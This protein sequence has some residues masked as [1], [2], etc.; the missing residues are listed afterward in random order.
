MVHTA[1]GAPLRVPFSRK[2]NLSRLGVA[3]LLAT[4]FLVAAAPVAQARITHIQILTRGTAFGGH[5]FAGVGQYEFITGIATGEVDPNNPQNSLITDLALA[6]KNAAGHVVY[7]HN[8]YILQPLDGS[9]GN[10][11][12][13]YEP[14][15]RGG[16]TYQ[17]LNN[18]PTGTDDPAALTD[19]AVLDDS[20]L[21]TRGYTTVWSGW[22]NNLGPL[23]GLTATASFPI[24]GTPANPITGPG[25]EYI[26]SPPATFQLN[27]P[28]ASADQSK[29]TLTHRI[30]LDDTPVPVPA[31]GWTYV[32][33]T[34][35]ADGSAIP[36]G[37]IKLTTGPFVANDIYEFSYTAMN[38]TVNGL[39]LA[40][41][42]DFNSFL[43]Y[44]SH[45]D[46]GVQNPIKFHIDRIY[47]ETSSQPGRTLND[48]VHLGF[49]EDENHKQVFD[50][51]MQW[52]AAGDGLNMNYR[53]SQTKRTNRNRQELL[54]LE[55][56]YP[57]ANVPTF[58]PISGTSDWRYKRC[59]ET[60]TCPLATEFYSANEFWVKAGSLMST[61][62]TGK[63]DL[64]DHP[65]AR[66]YLLSSKQHG[67]AGNPASRGLC[68]Q[69]LNP[70]DSAPVQRALWTALDEWSM[71]GIQPPPSQV[72]TFRDGTLVPP[73]Q[74][75]VGFP[76]IP[77]VTY[78]GLKT[79]R[80]R[81]NYGKD[82]YQTFVPTINPPLISPP[83]YE[84]NP[85]NGPIYPSFVPKTD[86]D[87]NDIAGIRL[88]ELVVPLATYTGWGLRSG[89]W[90]NDGC[91]ASGQYIPFQS[92][93]A[94]RALIGDP[95][96]SVQERYA[97]FASY[98]ARVVAAVD[99]LVRNRFFICDDT[100]DIVNRLL[101]AGL[102]AGV[103]APGP[104]DTATSP[105]PV[106]ACQGRMPNNYHYH[107]V[108]DR[109]E[110]QGPGRP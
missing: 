10:R 74:T 92:T 25:Y 59:E 83:G 12:M 35:A 49:N 53:W 107:L 23:N 89:I 61:D 97:T 1:S 51:M 9:R 48:F 65:L 26:V 84:D 42:R 19:P 58:D 73:A 90:Q 82:F 88:P 36:N 30:H 85:L 63:F 28:A 52:I 3:G 31:S 98:K 62:P 45:D 40:A 76:S 8:F 41:I 106:P 13:M 95:R 22:E 110:G 56:L 81:F 21:W 32:N 79:T 108:Y 18:T 69:F 17:T 72:P 46:G 101:Q 38:P 96:P 60:H 93:A 109:D 57:F 6:P 2:H 91:E 100:Q 16:K 39:G 66:N 68:Q 54:Y 34:N 27:Y 94:A 55:G 11:K 43:R 44:S 20:F 105:N 103:P 14:P 67:G 64:P 78:T 47:T 86:S 33:G 4:T 5:S 29:A 104:N 50:G 75:S 77:H 80:Y 71:F 37:A 24:A 99:G 102:A 7:Q 15:N 87:G 70:L